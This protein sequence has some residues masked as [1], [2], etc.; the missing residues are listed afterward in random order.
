MRRAGCCE[1]EGQIQMDTD[2]SQRGELA[3]PGPIS[4]TKSVA[5]P[6]PGLIQRLT[7]SMNPTS[8]EF[9]MRMLFT[10][11]YWLVA[12]LLANMIDGKT[13]SIPSLVPILTEYFKEQFSFLMLL[14]QIMVLGLVAL[15][16]LFFAKAWQREIKREVFRLWYTI[17]AAAGALSF[18]VHD[19]M[20]AFGFYLVAVFVPWLLLFAD[21]PFPNLD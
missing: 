19:M 3:A 18:V 10:V 13:V 12:A 7:D 1:N 8:K 5:S 9:G 4:S 21:A 11:A 17:G 14:F 15:P 6:R 20:Y 16:A 2:D